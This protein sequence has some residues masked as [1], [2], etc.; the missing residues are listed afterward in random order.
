MAKTQ[1]TQSRVSPK[2][3]LAFFSA[4]VVVFFLTASVISI[5]TKYV[6]IRKTVR[7]LAA[8]E[9]LLKTKQQL[10]KE[11]NTFLST[12]EGQEHAVREAF[13]M[14]RSGEGV[15]MVIPENMSSQ[16]KPKENSSWWDTILRGV[17]LRK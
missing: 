4:C 14:V 15:I 12:E 3:I 2:R 1:L 10:L 16:Q 7:D 5:V 9:Q 17:G 13:N 6:R 8:Q 11:K